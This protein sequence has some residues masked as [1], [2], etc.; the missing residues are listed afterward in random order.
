MIIFLLWVL[1]GL[2]GKKILAALEWKVGVRKGS[3]V[4]DI[5][6]RLIF[7]EIGVLRFLFCVIFFHMTIFYVLLKHLLGL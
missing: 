4:R 6:L 5:C 2:K 1:I 3:A 7:G